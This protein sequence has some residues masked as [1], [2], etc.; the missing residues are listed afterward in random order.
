M[1]SWRVV[2]GAGAR[3]EV[4]R[5]ASDHSVARRVMARRLRRRGAIGK[6]YLHKNNVCYHKY[7]P[8]PLRCRGGSD[9]AAAA[10][11]T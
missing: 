2:F 9:D 5:A 4:I 1:R 8:S 11:T 7:S 3:S 6:S 10:W